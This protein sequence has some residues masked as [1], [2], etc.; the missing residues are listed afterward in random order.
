MMESDPARKSTCDL[1]LGKR[2][3]GRPK[4]RWSE[5]VERGLKGVGVKNWKK[6]FTGKG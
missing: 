2:T 1:F 5:E 4:G 3:V 6:I